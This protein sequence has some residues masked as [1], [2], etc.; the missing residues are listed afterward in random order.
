MVVHFC[1]C[2]SGIVCSYSFP[3]LARTKNLALPLRPHLLCR[4]LLRSV[5]IAARSGAPPTV[6]PATAHTATAHPPHFLAPPPDSPPATIVTTPAAAPAAMNRAIMPLSRLSMSKAA[7]IGS[8]GTPGQFAG[9]IATSSLLQVGH[10]GSQLVGGV[11]AKR[12][13]R[14]KYL[15]G[16][17]RNPRPHSAAVGIL[18]PQEVV[19]KDVD[20][21]DG[22]LVRRQ[23]AG[24][25]EIHSPRPSVTRLAVGTP[26]V[27][28]RGDGRGRGGGEPSGGAAP[29]RGGEPRRRGFSA[30]GGPQR[31]GR[32]ARREFLSPVVEDVGPTCALSVIALR[33]G[34]AR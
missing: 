20:A 27:G 2:L 24:T 34:A 32:A 25:A 12:P 23:R 16:G 11:E 18:Q 3:S 4:R 17:K 31:T 6:L 19:L 15:V 13:R 22:R 14:A 33:T 26:T 1:A 7:R 9:R 30:E 29:K 8:T 10:L 5:L 28:L 21:Q